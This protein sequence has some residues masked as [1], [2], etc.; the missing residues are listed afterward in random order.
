LGLSPITG[1]QLAKLMRKKKEKHKVSGRSNYVPQF[2]GEPLFY[3]PQDYLMQV[4]GRTLSGGGFMGSAIMG[5]KKLELRCGVETWRSLRLQYRDIFSPVQSGLSRTELNY[6]LNQFIRNLRREL[7]CLSGHEFYDRGKLELLMSQLRTVLSEM[8]GEVEE[9]VDRPVP[10][11]LT[12]ESLHQAMTA[13]YSSID[14][15]TDLLASDW[16]RSSAVSLSLLVTK[17]AGFTLVTW[18][19]NI[20][21][22]P[23]DVQFANV[24]TAIRLGV[25]GRAL[26]YA[27][28]TV[29]DF[30]TLLTYSPPTCDSSSLYSVLHSYS[31]LLY[32]GS[33]T[34]EEEGLRDRL[35]MSR[36]FYEAKES[37]SC[38]TSTPSQFLDLEILESP[39]QGRILSDRMED[40][41]SIIRLRLEAA[42]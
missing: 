17:L 1:D 37:V 3:T 6:R 21:Q 23:Q 26:L 22:W 36:F 13:V 27:L 7:Q 35:R 40:L 4:V 15:T 8:F 29:E 11:L 42:S 38:L 34:R 20:G 28:F 32:P 9:V 12:D 10:Q 25:L 33:S 24:S 19:R 14:R 41:L 18:G 2:P 30:R 31:D 39:D 5:L 16:L